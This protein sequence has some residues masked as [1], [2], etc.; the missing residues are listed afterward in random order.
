[1]T[2]SSASRLTTSSACGRIVRRR[3][4]SPSRRTRAR[5]V[6]R[7]GDDVFSRVRV[8]DDRRAGPNDL[9]RNENPL[10]RHCCRPR[11]FCFAGN[12]QSSVRCFDLHRRP[13]NGLSFAERGRLRC[14]EARISVVASGLTTCSLGR[15]PIELLFTG[16]PWKSFECGVPVPRSQG[17]ICNILA[18]AQERS[19]P[20]FPQLNTSFHTLCRTHDA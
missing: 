20:Q 3:R 12:R 1:M 15:T 6:S 18:C 10:G 7:L 9:A 19:S 11:G 14:P 13:T 2:R 8:G 16:V 5:R 4:S 17:R